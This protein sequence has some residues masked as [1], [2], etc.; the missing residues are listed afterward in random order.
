MRTLLKSAFRTGRLL[1]GILVLGI[2]LHGSAAM[3]SCYAGG[4]G[5][6]G[7][8]DSDDGGHG[9]KTPEID[10]GSIVGALTLLTGGVLLLTDRRGRK[11]IRPAT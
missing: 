6:D 11:A 9:G 4:G 7:G 1:L 10:P 5:G 2:A 8:G 3:N